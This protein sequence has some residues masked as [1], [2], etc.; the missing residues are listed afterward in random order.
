MEKAVWTPKRIL[1]LAIG[2]ALFFAAYMVYAHF[3]GGI[4][5]L[6]PLPDDYG[7]I[8]DGVKHIVPEER[9]NEADHKLRIAF[10][11]DCDE[12]KKFNI[13]VE[14]Q[15][16]GMVLA[17][18]EIK[19]EDGRVKLIPFSFAIFG[20]DREGEKFPEINT[21]QCHEA[22][23]TF[24]KPVN[25]IAEVGSSARKITAAELSGD[26]Y[27]IN[28]RRTP[29]RDDDLSLFT[30]GPLY[31]E[32]SLHRVWTGA[33][34]RVTDLQSK[35]KPMVICG[36]RMHL[37]LAAENQPGDAGKAAATR[38]KAGSSMKVER[39]ELESEVDMNLWADARSG[40]LGGGKDDSSPEQSASPKPKSMAT[41]MPRPKEAAPAENAKVKI[42]TQGPFR[43][44]LLTDRAT[45]D[46]SHHSGPRP[47]VVT[48]DRYQEQEDKID[49][50]E[51]DHL[52]IQFQRKSPAAAQAATD[53]RGEGLDIE[54]VHA[55]GKEVIL[56]SDAELLEAHGTDF[57][58]DK[59]TRL[60]ILKGQPKMWALK[61]GN[62]IE[63]PELQLTDGKGTQQAT[64]LG[65]GHI[66]MLDKKTGDRP[67]EAHWKQKLIYAKDGPH[68]LLSLMGSAS[69]VDH[70]HAQ[71]LEAQLLKVWL[72]PHKEGKASPDSDAQ[73]PLPRHVDA[74]GQVRA[75]AP[76]ML[77]HDTDHLVLKFKDVAPTAKSV[78]A[79]PSGRETRSSERA[80]SKPA[81]PEP[82]R[83]PS[84]EDAAGPAPAPV[85]PREEAVSPGKPS[86][87]AG[88]FP[89]R[90]SRGE[91]VAAA[92]AIPANAPSNSSK[93]KKPLDLSAR[94]IEAHVLRS[95]SKNELDK[96]WC[97]GAVRILQ[98][99]S[100]PDDKGVDVRGEKLHLV[101][102]ADGNILTVIGDYAH[103]QL[104]KLYIVGPEVNIDQ[105]TNEAWVNGTG[106][107]KLPGNG[108]IYGTKPT[109]PP[110]A[111]SAEPADLTIAW[112]KHMLF[113][114]QVARFD[115][116]SNQRRGRSVQAELESGRLACKALQV[117]LDR[118]I[119]LREGEKG[120][121]QANVQKVVCDKDVWVEDC[122]REGSRVVDYDR[123]DC[124]LLSVDNGED[125][126]DSVVNAGGPGTV[127][128][129]QF[130]TKEESAA[131]AGAS[132]PA[133]GRA[134]ANPA[135]PKS[136][137]ESE[138]TRITYE[139]R[140]YAN[141]K[142]GIAKF[143]DKVVVIHVPT[144]DP[145]LP[146]DDNHL[147]P[148]YLYMS[149]E[150]LEVLKSK[151]PDGK[152]TQEMRA[153][154]KVAIE[155]Q[156]FSGNAD[157]V[158]YDESKEQVILEG[159]DANP[160]VLT[161]QKGRGA[162]PDIVRGR[163]ITYH[164]LTGEYEVEAGSQIQFSQ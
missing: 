142:Q 125:K 67:L 62:E 72:E 57:F 2:F 39:I 141:K 120:K 99:P 107:M 63:A 132:K 140:M 64:A 81:N 111:K 49:H 117:T 119:S 108:N 27:I 134:A 92:G 71:Q 88:P 160:A 55:T 104:D 149:C 4:N 87:P 7:P 83:P 158:K 121:Q 95:E 116:P 24:D 20:K 124:P 16:R 22:K 105:T 139:S 144:D 114:G 44:D 52:E 48:V 35:P 98:E 66:R 41:G 11:P 129:F 1:L 3:L 33:V 138:L 69:F 68:D 128:I 37:Y 50:L 42:M 102:Q 60:S 84:S 75:V 6:P 103:V 162:K 89:S 101:R 10:G 59:R 32:E 156:E 131:Q 86:E 145:H 151:L 13:K 15:S 127:R 79:T 96:L 65:E 56:T 130:G 8:A 148:G 106:I 36:T 163:K 38:A 18:Q 143:W 61:E 161:K 85:S 136:K 82:S 19:F 43:Y 154:G 164:R 28:N 123:I 80:A 47:N 76:D 53:S 146:I 73:R 30:Q 46:I 40:F 45:F 34:V 5:G 94:Y 51:C 153:Y 133:K 113:D 135:Q 14:L 23:L 152:T 9:E 150:R 29:Q 118:M 17:S 100:G 31:Y 137:E 78:S 109:K 122:K 54:T 25:N 155:T 159:S 90:E 74:L 97:E 70:E 21:I 157:V 110:E 58:H 147:P 115:W 77:I 112:E 12:V 26:I 93:P 126:D 91:P